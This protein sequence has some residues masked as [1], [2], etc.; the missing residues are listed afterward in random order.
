MTATVERPPGEEQGPC[1]VVMAA[2]TV[3]SVGS[4]GGIGGDKGGCFPA[5]DLQSWRGKGEG[6]EQKKSRLDPCRS[7][8]IPG[9]EPPVNPNARDLRRADA[10]SAC[11]ILERYCNGDPLLTK[12]DAAAEVNR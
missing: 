5:G 3:A 12:A 8:T 6:P 1:T 11:A 9:K 10:F 7:P 4:S 2:R